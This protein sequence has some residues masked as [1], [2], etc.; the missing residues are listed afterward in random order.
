L[1][2]T[3]RAE[4]LRRLTLAVLAAALVVA[5]PADAAR[6]KRDRTP[7]APVKVQL[8]AINDFHGH[9]ESTTP[10]KIARGTLRRRDRVPAGGAEFLATHVRLLSRRKPNTLVVAAGDLVGA[11]P[12]LSALFHDEP[13]IEAMNE[14]GLDVAA[15]GNHEFDEG[16]AELVRLQRGGCHPVDGCRDGT[17]FGGADFR[18][19]AANVVSRR[20]G[21]PLFPPYAIRRVGGVRI[22]FIGMTLEGTPDI[23][24]PSVSASLRFADE[25]ETA[26]RYVRQLR[27]RKVQA[28]VVLLHEGGAPRARALADDCP[29]LSGP[30]EDIVRRTSA[31]VDAFITGHTHAA[32]N[33]VL[34]RRR[35]TS[36]G[37]FGRLITRLELTVDRRRNDVVRARADNWIVG[38][39][40][41]RAPD[42]TELI[43]R[44]AALADP[45][46]LRVIGRLAASASRTADNSGERR[47]GNLIADAQAS[48]VGADAAFVNP[49]EVRTGIAAGDVTV[50]GAFRAQPFGSSVVAMTLT[51]S[52]ILALLKEQWCGRERQRVLAPSA[53]VSY[54]WSLGA[55]AAIQGQPCDG[56]L[57]PVS[58]LR[59][60]GELVEP[61]AT[62]RV[63]VSSMLAGGFNRFDV[64]EAGTDR[65]D[66]PPDTVALEAH[67][68][69]SLTGDPIVPP[70]TTRI[71]VVP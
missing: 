23:V 3:S 61:D 47:V 69:P 11:S 57:N 62:Y 50:A 66:G 22:G 63:A 54:L 21:K 29:G 40:V 13:A 71:G 28:I 42:L 35:V 70:E 41:M 16:A 25:A 44:Y 58:E 34:D 31:E 14:I 59:I 37:S 49:G 68:A 39:D 67:L 43:A 27:R 52:Q 53:A 56:A 10:G 33:C 60:R 1:R 55:A 5:A 20:T 7:P 17:P 48:A 45:L 12:L 32:Y 24:P 9:L 8:L 30:I 26:N 51:G 6:K 2:R 38:Q 64:L 19:L 15:V 36:A 4:R 46:R 18:Y 65:G